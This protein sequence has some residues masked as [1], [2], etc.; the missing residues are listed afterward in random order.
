MKYLRLDSCTLETPTQEAR[1]ILRLP[2]PPLPLQPLNTA[3]LL[4]LQHPNTVPQ[5][6]LSTMLLHQ[7]LHLLLL[8]HLTPCQVQAVPAHTPLLPVF[9]QFPPHLTVQLL[10]QLQLV[11]CQLRMALLLCQEHLLPCRQLLPATAALDRHPPIPAHWYPHLHRLRQAIVLVAV[12]PL[13]PVPTAQCLLLPLTTIRSYHLPLHQAHTTLLLALLQ[14]L[15]PTAQ[16]LP[17]LQVPTTLFLAPL[18][19]QAP[20]AQCLLQLQA[21]TT[22]LLAPLLPPALTAQPLP[23]PP[24]PTTLLPTLLQLQAPIAQ[25]LPLR[26]APTTQLQVPLL[27]QALTAQCPIQHPVPTILLLVLLLLLVLITRFLLQRPALTIPLPAPLLRLLLPVVTSN[28]PQLQLLPRLLF[29][30]SLRLMIAS[31]ASAQSQL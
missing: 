27:P 14:L 16:C 25:Y 4:Q 20:T 10:L 7:H 12:L 23:L 21:P 9:N 11:Q 29:P 15:A 24:A 18:Q 17:Q 8:D 5:W 19:L 26:Q 28:Q 30:M 13:P 22:P 1:T 6:L 2:P 31:Q 3:P